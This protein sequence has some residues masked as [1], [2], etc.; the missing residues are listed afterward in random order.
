MFMQANVFDVDYSSLALFDIALC[1]GLLYHVS[2]PMEL[3]EKIAAVNIDVP[4]I[5]TWVATGKRSFI[6]I[7]HKDTTDPRIRGMPLTTS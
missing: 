6:E 2:K 4:L 3:S 5:D 7:R 1:L